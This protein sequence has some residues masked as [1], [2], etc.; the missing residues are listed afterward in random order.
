MSQTYTLTAQVLT[1][2]EENA[3]LKC[4]EFGSCPRRRVEEQGEGGE[5]G[6]GG[7]GRQRGGVV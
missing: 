2:G 6:E 4:F 5:G 1:Q 7:D 3:H